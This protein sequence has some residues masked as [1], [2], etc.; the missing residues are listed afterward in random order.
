MAARYGLGRADPEAGESEE[1]RLEVD[2]LDLREDPMAG[3][4]VG[5]VKF[6]CNEGSVEM[7]VS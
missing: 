2:M 4:G 3:K 1:F 5:E 6:W 7:G